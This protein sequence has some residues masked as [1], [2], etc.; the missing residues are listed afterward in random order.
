[1]EEIYCTVWTK[2]GKQE[3]TLD[4]FYKF[5]WGEF[6]R[7]DGP[8]IEYADGSKSWWIYGKIHCL[9]GPAIEW[10]DE[11][12]EWYIKGKRHRIDGPAVEWSDG[13]KFWYVDGRILDTKEVESWLKEN[14]VDLGTIEGQMAFKLRWI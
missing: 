13:T 11:S 7:L 8:A 12:K 3:L 9:D 1:M 4:Q 14:N 6:H 5:N 10:A 2:D